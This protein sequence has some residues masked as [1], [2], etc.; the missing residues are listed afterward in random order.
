MKYFILFLIVLGFISA[1]VEARTRTSSP[2][3]TIQEEDASPT[4][5]PRTLK[6]TNG[7]LTDNGDGS[8]SLST[9]AG[10][11][12]GSGVFE[13]V[14]GELQL[15]ATNSGYN[16]NLQNDLS[17]TNDLTVDAGVLYV[18]SANNRVGVNTTTPSTAV[19]VIGDLSVSQS[20]TAS[21]FFAGGGSASKLVNG[22]E[23]FP[24]SVK[25]PGENL[26]YFSGMDAEWAPNGFTLTD[27]VISRDLTVDTN[28]VT[29]TVSK[30]TNASQPLT[31]IEEIT[32]DSN[33]WRD[34]DDGTLTVS[35]VTA[36]D[37]IGF[38]VNTTQSGAI[39]AL[40]LYG[41]KNNS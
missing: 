5:T 4:G 40:R 12:S 16:V 25:S 9:G 36:D 10:E 26:F 3:L 14:D 19:E 38:A 28:N 17:I 27:V 18:D 11:G 30:R 22:I 15:D 37:E 41:Y 6:V 8:F 7:S 21:S 33:E 1:D 35:A 2:P 31:T 32:L 39:Y 24:I 29:V 20:I 34:E 23:T 13:L